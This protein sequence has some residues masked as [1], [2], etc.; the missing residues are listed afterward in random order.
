VTKLNHHR[1]WGEAVL[2]EEKI[3]RILK[4]FGLTETEGNLYLFLARCGALKGTEIARQVKKDKGQVYRILKNLQAKGLVEATLEAP[5]RFTTVPF[6]KVVESTIKA[7][8]DEAARIESIKQELFDYWKNTS[9]ARPEAPLEKFLVIKGRKKIYRKILQMINETKSQLSTV[10]T[11]QGLLR[12][13]QFG[14]LDAAFDHPLK[15]QVQFRFLT[16]L[17]Q[18]NVNSIKTLLKRKPRAR[19]NFKGRNPNLGLRL[20]PRMVIR[21]EEEILLFITP[22]TNVSSTA[23]DETCLWTNGKTLVQSFSAVFENLWT[24]STDINEKIAEIETGKPTPTARVISDLRTARKTYDE[25]MNSAEKE[26]IL[27]TSSKG[28]IESWKSIPLLKER[29]ERGVSVKIMAPIIKDN[30]QAAQELLKFCAVRHVPTSYFDTVIVDGKRLFQSQ[31]ST[32]Q[33]PALTPHFYTDD[34][35][36]VEKTK[37]MLNDVWRSASVPS[38]VT[39]EY[40][41]KPSIPAVAPLSYHEGTWSRP[42]S[43]HKKMIYDVVEKPGVITEKDVLNKIINA[44]KYPANWPKDP[45]RLYGSTANAVIHPPENFHLPDIMIGANHLNKESS[46]G[47][48]DVL[49]ISLWL[50]TPKGF[51][52][53]PVARVSDDTKRETKGP[54]FGNAIYAGTPAG[55]NVQLVKKDELQIRFHGN[56]F[57]AGWTKPIPLIPSK[58]ILPPSCILLEGYS[59]LGTS[60]IDYVLPSGAK[61]NVEVNGFEAFVTFFHPASKYS[62]PGTDGAIGRDV[63]VTI[64]PP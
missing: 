32:G 1:R 61:V 43:P 37:K 30:L 20:S 49:H 4:D 22:R 33:K 16:E 60:V 51:A 58:Y 41:M 57:F 39:L 44:K 36:Y 48:G 24:N 19:V 55:Q 26:I 47:A 53:V 12:A 11:V 6:K 52:Y 56:T 50:E 31:A 14:L 45:I 42:D 59:K 54:D 17:S 35:E 64:Y 40:I 10:S 27:M 8:R 15:S 2:S 46:F 7:K 29:I 9:R 13:D 63:V 25:L 21:D 5:I 62:G 23:R 28:L 38:A 3:K 34:L 18:Q